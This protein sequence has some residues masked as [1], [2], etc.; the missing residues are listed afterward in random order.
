M[1]CVTENVLETVTD[2][3]VGDVALPDRVNKIEEML[4][5]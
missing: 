2:N 3:Q 1:V 4:A 5:Q